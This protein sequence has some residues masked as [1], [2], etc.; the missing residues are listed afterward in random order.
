MNSKIDRIVWIN[1]SEVIDLLKEIENAI[2]EP[3]LNIP[4]NMDYK[5]YLSILKQ[6]KAA[7]RYQLYNSFKF[8]TKS[9]QRKIIKGQMEEIEI[10]KSYY[11]DRVCTKYK[12]EKSKDDDY[13]ILM[14]RLKYEFLLDSGFVESFLTME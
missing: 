10:D 6:V 3:I 1:N 9:K 4:E 5:L 7:I 8:M 11:F 13:E 14:K 12:V 2:N